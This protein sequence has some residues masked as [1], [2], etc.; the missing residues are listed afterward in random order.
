MMGRHAG[1][2]GKREE[3]EDACVCNPTWDL[4][5]DRDWW[6][7]VI[8]VLSLTL[9][10]SFDSATIFVLE[11]WKLSLSIWE[12]SSLERLTSAYVY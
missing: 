1:N 3:M 12:D 2:R 7:R 10:L 8:T 5:S 6:G 4:Q 9:G 11:P